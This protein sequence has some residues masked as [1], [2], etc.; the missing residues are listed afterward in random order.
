MSPPRMLKQLQS[1]HPVRY[2]LPTENQI[3]KIISK[4]TT[5]EKAKRKDAA[6]ARAEGT[7]DGTR[8]RGG[9]NVACTEEANG[10][11][12]ER[13]ISLDGSVA[14]AIAVNEISEI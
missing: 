9:G 10:R 2:D 5:Y 12:E 4:L 1:M 7:S 3:Q 13:D 11:R 14:M 8:N 6:T